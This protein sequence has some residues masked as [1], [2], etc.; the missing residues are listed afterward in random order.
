MLE[1]MKAEKLKA[2]AAVYS[3]VMQSLHVGRLIQTHSMHMDAQ[4]FAS[5]LQLCP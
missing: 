5:L 1:V 4:P 3:S 2:D